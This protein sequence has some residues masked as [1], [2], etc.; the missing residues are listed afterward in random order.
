MTM[1]TSRTVYLCMA[2]VLVVMLFAGCAAKRAVQ[3]AAVPS[4]PPP[5]TESAAAPGSSADAVSGGSADKQAAPAPTTN[6][7]TNRKIITT[8]NMTIEVRDLSQAVNDLT[9]LVQQ[10]GGFFANKTV[11]A[12]EVWRRA[13]VTIRVPADHFDKLHDGARALGDVKR[14][15]QQGEDVT[16]EWQD[17][18]ARIK[19]QQAEEQSLVRLMAQQGRLADLLE[20]EKRLWDVRVQIE[21]AQGELRVMR[22]KVTLA[23]LTVTLNEALPAGVGKVGPWNLGYHVVTAG[24]TLVRAVK[25]IL[26]AVIYAVVVGAVVWLPLLLII[27]WLRRRAQAR[28][29]NLPPPPSPPSS[30][31]G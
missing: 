22:D 12:E 20:I 15:D 8:G 17:L 30:A 9:R 13:E 5:A 25:A 28:R 6:A 31:T 24:Q 29:A 3:E 7:A 18:E 10:H 14:D 26:I 27:L 1:K 23:T 16:K 11:S 21:Q 2:V 19:I 4:A